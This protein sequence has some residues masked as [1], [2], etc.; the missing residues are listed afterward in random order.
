MPD[1]ISCLS[2]ILYYRQ[3]DYGDSMVTVE[4]AI[5]AR[6]TKDGKHFEILV[7]PYIAYDLKE[8][9][10]VS[11]G[12]MLAANII[13]TD[14]RKSTKSNTS[15]MQA[16]FATTD[17]EKVAEVIVKKGDLQ[18]TTEFRRKKIDERKRQVASF[19]SRHAI[20]PQTKLPHPQERVLN[21]MGMAKVNIDPFKG[22]EQQ[23]DDVIKALKTVLPI[24]MEEVE[25]NIEVPAQYAGHAHG[26][27]KSVV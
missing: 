16:V 20:N 8:G 15:D 17:V 13:F 19:I 26:D 2:Y 9:R 23:V 24:S 14:A 5:I 11:L 6:Y 7:D 25:L 3:L 1:T 4:D 18:L 21:A 27:R 12:R 22:A 10:T